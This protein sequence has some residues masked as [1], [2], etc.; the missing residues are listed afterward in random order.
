MFTWI[1]MVTVVVYVMCCDAGG[2]AKYVAVHGYNA[3]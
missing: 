2:T 1:M 3:C